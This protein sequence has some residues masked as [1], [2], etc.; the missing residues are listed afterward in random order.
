MYIYTADGRHISHVERDRVTEGLL[1]YI[2]HLFVGV[3]RFVMLLYVCGGVFWWMRGRGKGGGAL[4]QDLRNYNSRSKVKINQVPGGTFLKRS[5]PLARI[6]IKGK[7]HN[8]W[9]TICMHNFNLNSMNDQNLHKVHVLLSRK[10]IH[11]QVF[12]YLINVNNFFL[13]FS[14]DKF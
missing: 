5:G 12:L 4:G 8:V 10:C 2:V 9:W 7:S 13:I 11:Y 6:K 14:K 1:R 3:T